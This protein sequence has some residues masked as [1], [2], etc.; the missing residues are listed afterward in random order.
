MTSLSRAQDLQ[1]HE[2][3]LADNAIEAAMVD[4]A[5]DMDDAGV[6]QSLGLVGATHARVPYERLPG[7][8]AARTADQRRSVSPVALA[9]L[10]R[11]RVASV[12]AV[13]GLAMFFII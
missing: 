6:R 9:D 7:D 10:A 8:P 12:D 1:Q 3:A 2:P 4:L 13:R 11:E 5:R